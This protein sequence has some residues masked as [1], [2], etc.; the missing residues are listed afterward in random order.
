VEGPFLSAEDGPR[1]VHDPAHI[2]PAD[3]AELRR[4][5]PLVGLVTVSPHNDAAIAFISEATRMQVRCAIGHTH[6]TPGQI[7][8]AIDAGAELA[9]HLGNGAHAMLPRHPNYLWT[10]LAD[11][12][13]HAGL[14]ADGHHLPADTFRAMLAA[15]G[16]SRS[17]LV[18]DVTALGGMPPGR[19]RT[20]VGRDV[21]LSPDGRLSYPGT[22]FLAGASRSLADGVAT[23]VT[24]GGLTLST[25]LRLATENP[26][27][28]TG[29]R[30]RL[31]P[32][33][34]ADVM[35]FGWRPGDA[36]L[37]VQT[38]LVAGEPVLLDGEPTGG[39]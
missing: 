21:E 12:R 22:P 15:K 32:G 9:T 10:Q 5:G 18:S 38:V 33:A 16:V 4:W 17:H 2:R 8:C 24:L 14:I 31:R 37:D 26:G 28:F 19:Y 29:G 20:P 3:L 35:T 25:A 23:A 27:R 13:L 39:R 11:D 30:G 34:P 7:T 6:A 1:G 36:T